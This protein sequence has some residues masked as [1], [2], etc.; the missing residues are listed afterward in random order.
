[1]TIP[2][3]LYFLAGLVSFG[4]C[5]LLVPLCGWTARRFDILDRPGGRKNH[6]RAVPLL[7]G[8]AI[9]VSVWGTL[10]GLGVLA[11]ALLEMRQRGSLR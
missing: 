3:E 6:A 10:L 7:G 1:M 9:F 11:E 5:Y 2:A 8:A 4:L